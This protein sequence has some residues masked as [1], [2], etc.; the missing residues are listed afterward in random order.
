VSVT[1]I[2]GVV[3]YTVDNLAVVTSF[4]AYAYFPLNML[5]VALRVFENHVAVV[6]FCIKSTN[7]RA[8]MI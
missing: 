4:E 2:P 8:R 3:L 7:R 5:F 6:A 1:S